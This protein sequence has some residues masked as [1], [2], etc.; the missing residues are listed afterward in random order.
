MAEDAD[1][2]A[3]QI[4]AERLAIRGDRPPDT[5]RVLRVVP[6]QRL[7][8]Q[9]AVLDGPRQ[10]ATVVERVG[11]RDHAGPAH[12]AERRHE[13][14]DAA[15]RRRP[16]DRSAGIGAERQRDH[17]RRHGRPRSR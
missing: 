15:E 5:A 17:A 1:L 3:A 10:G 9:R 14:N 16:A 13:P 8:R 7:Q 6:G 11:V 12:Q 4:L 2:E